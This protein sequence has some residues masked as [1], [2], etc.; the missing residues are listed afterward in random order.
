MSRGL[1]ASGLGLRASGVGL[2]ACGFRLRLCDDVRV[3][4]SNSGMVRDV[5]SSMA[6]S[7][8]YRTPDARSST[9]VHRR[10]DGRFFNPWPSGEEHGGT[11]VLKWAIERRKDR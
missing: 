2:R 4:V 7:P 10:P 8:Q 3:S 11:D 6:A 1:R 9:L 5:H